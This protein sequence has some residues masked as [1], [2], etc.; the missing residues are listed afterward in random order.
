MKAFSL[1]IIV[2]QQQKKID[3]ANKLYDIEVEA[4]ERRKSMKNRRNQNVR[5][6][7]LKLHKCVCMPL[8]R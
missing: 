2:S 3:L 4:K 5:T 6:V 7:T 1:E 8:V